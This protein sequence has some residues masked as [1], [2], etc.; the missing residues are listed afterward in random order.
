[1]DHAQH[2]R[3]GLRQ[4]AFWCAALVLAITSLSA[5][6]R[7]SQAGL[8]CEPWPPCFG[9]ALHAAQQGMVSPVGDSPPVQMA[10]LAHRVIATVALAGTATMVAL[11]FM[12]RPKMWR[13]GLLALALLTLALGLAVLGV[14][15]KGSRLPAVA[16]GNLLG[17]MLMF[18]LCWRLAAPLRRPDQEAGMA[19]RALAGLAW[20]VLLGQLGLGALTSASYAGQSCTGVLDCLRAADAAHWPWAML[21]PWREPVWD[22]ARVPL[23]EGAAL[24]QLLHR[25]GAMVL[26]LLLVALATLALRGGRR[27]E[28]W[29][30][31][32]LL[33]LQLVAGV[34]MV[35]TGLALPLAL[36]HNL[37]A[38]LLLATL[39]RLI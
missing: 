16:M 31:L 29:S 11:C 1:M 2:R 37:L 27:R 4:L 36:A 22:A 39:V 19:M 30:L 38:A 28:A 24:T 9:S 34:L 3:D 14:W 18:A 23:N 25:A 6:I 10:R 33:A 21:D 8:G 32:I 13:K 15:T 12:G 26:A 5:F 35:D 7:Q 20:F 17:G